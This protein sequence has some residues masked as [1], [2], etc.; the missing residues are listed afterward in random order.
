MFSRIGLHKP[1]CTGQSPPSMTTQDRTWPADLFTVAVDIDY[2]DRLVS[3]E[4]AGVGSRFVAC[5]VD[6]VIKVPLEAGLLFFLVQIRP[7]LYS[8]WPMTVL[9]CAIAVVNIIYSIAF[10]F[11]T[12]G[13][14]PGKNACGIRVM[15]ESGR[16]AGFSQIFIRNV[17]RVVDWLPAVYIAGAVFA[18]A[19]R[20][21]QRFGDR[22]AG[23]VVVREESIKQLL[24]EIAVPPS[25]YSTSDD[26]YILEAFLSRFNALRE[27]VQLPLARQLAEYFYRKYPPQDSLL[28]QSY[29]QARYIDFLQELYRL[30]KA[31]Q[32]AE[33]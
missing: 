18:L 24:E 25:I 12:Q 14:T 5:L 27:E 22:I 10:E 8:F 21:G 7:E 4:L 23:T 9:I 20:K 3:H 19:N 16:G 33:G 6:T 31:R 26:G 29:A 32:K 13:Q 28:I 11:L 17:L 2:G 1:R 30:E 15:S